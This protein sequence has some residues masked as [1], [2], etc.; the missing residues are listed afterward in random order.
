MCWYLGVRQDDKIL[1][2]KIASTELK[3]F[4]NPKK[5]LLKRTKC[6]KNIK[7][8][9]STKD[10]T[11]TTESYLLHPFI[12]P[13]EI[14]W[15]RPGKGTLLHWCN[16]I[17]SCE[18]LHILVDQRHRCRSCCQGAC[19]IFFRQIVWLLILGG[20]NSNIFLAF[21]PRSLGE[22][23]QF[24]A[25][26]IWTNHQPMMVS[27]SCA[28]GGLATLPLPLDPCARGNFTQKTTHGTDQRWSVWFQWFQGWRADEIWFTSMVITRMTAIHVIFLRHVVTLVIQDEHFM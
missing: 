15:H 5:Q 7:I 11:E 13:E 20:G 9:K 21:S 2:A 25:W 8:K 1:F 22:M 26:H 6:W 14:C 17:N 16:N 3:Q 23:I 18:A 12:R 10:S 4:S 24:D 27:S 19:G 28:L